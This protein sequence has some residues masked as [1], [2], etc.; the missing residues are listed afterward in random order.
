[1]TTNC[2]RDAIAASNAPCA[3]W[4]AAESARRRVAIVE[5]VKADVLRDICDGRYENLGRLG[6]IVPFLPLQS[7]GR[8][9]VVERQLEHV[10][11]RLRDAGAG[12]ATLD[13]WSDHV[14]AH[15]LDHW[16][17]DTGG[18]STRDFIEENVVEAIADA[19]DEQE[20]GTAAADGAG[21]HAQAE[22]PGPTS[23]LL[24]VESDAA[25]GH[26]RVV[27]FFIGG[28]VSRSNHENVLGPLEGAGAR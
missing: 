22:P 14:V 20:L 18:R 28:G 24:D 10:A 25:S 21:E 7:S 26:E 19:L 13:G 8:R 16:D 3:P 27:R 6:T 4:A 15:T 11:Q 12:V 5:K 9:K 2:G 23:L 17:D 1:M